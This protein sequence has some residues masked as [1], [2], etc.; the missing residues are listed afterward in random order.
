MTVTYLKDGC[1]QVTNPHDALLLLLAGVNL[2]NCDNTVHEPPATENL[3]QLLNT[4]GSATGWKLGDTVMS[5]QID[6]EYKEP[7]S[8]L[9][10][11]ADVARGLVSLNCYDVPTW[12]T[13]GGI[14]DGSV[15][16]IGSGY[17][18]YDSVF[19]RRHKDRWNLLPEITMDK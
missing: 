5:I 13:T 11:P 9:Y 15:H 3:Y 1:I 6:P 18:G 12:N 2:V 8:V 10:I 14:E 4:D 17:D 7:N 19:L 16:Q